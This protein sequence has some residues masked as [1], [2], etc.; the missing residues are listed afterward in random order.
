MA[1]NGKTIGRL[2]PAPDR[3]KIDDVVRA[4]TELASGA[5]TEERANLNEY[6]RALSIENATLK[7]RLAVSEARLGVL[8]MAGDGAG[9]K[10]IGNIF[11]RFQSFEEAMLAT[12]KMSDEYKLKALAELVQDFKSF[13]AQKAKYQEWIDGEVAK[14]L[15][16]SKP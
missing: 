4:E 14:T 5:V 13:N 6:G 3:T 1:V 8:T 10:P 16:D 12:E 9:T 7:R 11:E 2:R 15:K